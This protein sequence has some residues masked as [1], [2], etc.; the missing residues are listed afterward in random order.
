[1]SA[2]KRLIRA[3]DRAGVGSQIGPEVSWLRASSDA[4]IANFINR[5]YGYP[6]PSNVTGGFGA[7]DQQI[8]RAA[9]EAAQRVLAVGGI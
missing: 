3:M 1:M 7:G 8:T 9:M 5:N 4:D 2:Q 6:I